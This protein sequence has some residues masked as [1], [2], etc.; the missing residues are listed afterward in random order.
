MLLVDE[1][2]LRQFLYET[3]DREGIPCHFC[4]CDGDTGLCADDCVEDCADSLMKYFQVDFSDCSADKLTTYHDI[5]TSY[6]DMIQD[7]LHQRQNQEKKNAWGNLVKQ[8]TDF[9]DKYGPIEIQD[10]PDG[11][12]EYI[13]DDF[14]ELKIGRLLL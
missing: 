7:E 12:L 9:T 8:L 4:P 1:T 2:K 14:I 5:L 6:D 11:D 13:H 10:G 3:Y